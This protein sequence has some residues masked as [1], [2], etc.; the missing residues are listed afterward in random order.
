MLAPLFFVSAVTLFDGLC[1]VRL[2][3]FFEDESDH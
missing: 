1:H 3:S 2:I